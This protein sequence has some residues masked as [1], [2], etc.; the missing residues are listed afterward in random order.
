[1]IFLC[2]GKDEELT[3][4]EHTETAQAPIKEEQGENTRLATL[5]N[6]KKFI[7]RMYTRL[8]FHVNQ[9]FTMERMLGASMTLMM[10]DAAED[11]YPNELQS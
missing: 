6:D 4:A 1:M 3:P 7:R 5:K 8:M 10:I 11:L 9:L 2:S